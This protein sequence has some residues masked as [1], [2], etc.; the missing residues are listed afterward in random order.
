MPYTNYYR[1][2]GLF[3]G[4]ALNIMGTRLDVVMTGDESLLTD[5]WEQ[6]ISDTER[7]HR[8]LNGFDAE[9]EISLINRQ[10]GAH[11]VALSDE[12]WD[13]MSDVQ[14]YHRL[15]QGYFDVSLRD[16]GKVVLNADNRSISFAENDVTVDLGGYAKGYA[17]ERL[18][19]IFL[20]AGVTQALVNFGNS[21]ILAVGAHPHGDY[22]GV[23]IENPYQPGQ[24]L[25]DYH[26]YNQSLSTSGNTPQH[27]EHII[28]PRSGKYSP[29]RKIV[30]AVSTNAIE[31]EVL[32][33]A[34]MVA[35]E[36]SIA[37][38]KKAFEN[39]VVDIFSVK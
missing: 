34:L 10:A 38:I 11:P 4:S 24:S 36:A 26:L 20:Q 5:V 31:A 18:W 13:I 3:H 25:K 21:S 2:S 29:E 7:L 15:T 39:V 28:N 37:E 23:G 27:A 14:K 19:G 6:I 35:D 32:S 30:S 33:T 17:L 9:S 1:K 12:L 22:W 8:M 16:L